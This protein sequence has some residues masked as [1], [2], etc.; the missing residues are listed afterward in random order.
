MRHALYRSFYL[1]NIRNKKQTYMYI[2]KRL[3]QR[4]KYSY[5]QKSK[6]CTT[7]YGLMLNKCCHGH[8]GFKCAQKNHRRLSHCFITCNWLL[9]SF[10]KISRHRARKWNLRKSLAQTLNPPLNFISLPRFRC[11]DI[12]FEIREQDS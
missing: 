2:R 3:K 11:R 5:S 10:H 7:C 9:H 1:F 12:F 8:Q 6:F 4:L